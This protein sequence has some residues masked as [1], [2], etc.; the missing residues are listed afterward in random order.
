MPTT[1]WGLPAHPLIVHVVVFLV[2][3]TVLAAMTTA[4]WPRA[5]RLLAPW[6]LGLATVTVL[7]I[8]LATESGEHL[9]DQVAR[10]SLVEEHAELGDTLLP[11]VAALWLALA[12]MVAVG[13]Y[14]RRTA[15][16]PPSWTK[17]VTMVAIV[18]TVGAA[19]GTGVQVVRI[20]HSGAQA[21]WHDTGTRGTTR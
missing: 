18:L 12:L 2:P 1:V 14:V 4:L 3:L 10:S 7:V 16:R 9:E 20:G 6:V 15:D 13:L 5:R 11:L 8:P 17:A 21:V 19:A